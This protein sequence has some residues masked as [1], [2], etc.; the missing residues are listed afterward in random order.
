MFENPLK[1]ENKRRF[2]RGIPRARVRVRDW[3][4]PTREQFA[5]LMAHLQSGAGNSPSMLR[6]A[7]ATK[8]K[9]TALAIRFLTYSGL[10]VGAARRVM[11]DDVDLERNFLLKPPIKFEDRA[12][13]LP[14]FPELRA[15]VEEMLAVYPGQ[16]SLMQI[17]DPSKAMQSA[18]DAIGIERLTCHA[19][20]HLFTTRCLESGVDVPTVAA[21]RG[22]KDGGA[23]LL[24]VY[25]HVMDEHSLQPAKKVRFGMSSG[26]TDS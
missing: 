4:L 14:M 11:P 21:W 7:T 16:G 9:R 10:R 3:K 18:C 23:M 1:I 12:K 17:A 2:I 15:V 13:R 6:D 19:L 20:R 22:D 26:T 25:A 8:R 24:K 5:A